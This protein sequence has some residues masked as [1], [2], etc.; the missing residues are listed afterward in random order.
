MF[1]ATRIDEKGQDASNMDMR[2]RIRERRHLASVIVVSAT[3]LWAVRLPTA[4]VSAPGRA[5]RINIGGR[6]AA[7][8]R[9]IIKLRPGVRNADLFDIERRGDIDRSSPLG[10][11]RTRLM[12]SRSRRA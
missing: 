7:A 2:A 9:I 12:R 3:L 11:G 6:E 5:E 8:E 10:N 1:C 4:Q